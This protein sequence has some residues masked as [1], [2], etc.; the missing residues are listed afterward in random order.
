MT[1]MSFLIDLVE[2]TRHAF[3]QMRW[4][5]R[6]E[7]AVA[8]TATPNVMIDLAKRAESRGDL[9]DAD[10]KDMETAMFLQEQYQDAVTR[11]LSMIPD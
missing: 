3:M 7:D 5:V 6:K 2:D 10:R 4:Y 1:K 9:Q 8:L 11:L